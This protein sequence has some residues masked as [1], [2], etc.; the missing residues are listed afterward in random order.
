MGKCKNATKGG[1]DAQKGTSPF[2]LSHAG[3]ASDT[4]DV[5]HDLR[6]EV[7]SLEEA[8]SQ[9]GTSYKMPFH[10]TWCSRSPLEQS[11]L[12]ENWQSDAA[13]EDWMCYCIWVRVT[14]G[15]GGGDQPPPPHAWTCSL[16]ANMSQGGLEEWILE[17]VVLAPGE[18][19]LF[20][21]WQSL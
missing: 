21:G 5:V 10:F 16:I 12:P 3:E 9:M 20:F 6:D 4:G 17:A 1:S 13:C 2:P 8:L 19:V 14:L 18:A 15:E 7:T 11:L